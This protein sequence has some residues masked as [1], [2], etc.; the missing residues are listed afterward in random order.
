MLFIIMV[1]LPASLLTMLLIMEENIFSYR[2][3]QRGQGKG[4]SCPEALRETR[5][6]QV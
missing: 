5:P 3:E 6:C 4:R 1:S 2:V